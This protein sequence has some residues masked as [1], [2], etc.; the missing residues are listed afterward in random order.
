MCYLGFFQQ[1]SSLKLVRTHSWKD[2]TSPSH[3]WWPWQ[4]PEAN[5]KIRQKQILF[6]K[7]LKYVVFTF[8]W[9]GSYQVNIY[10]HTSLTATPLTSVAWNKGDCSRETVYYF[11]SY[12]TKGLKNSTISSHDNYASTQA[13]T[14]DNKLA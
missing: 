11:F 7:S 2:P 6:H 12:L 5:V 8:L 4:L 14:C 9:H 13:C 3:E 1:S 10:M